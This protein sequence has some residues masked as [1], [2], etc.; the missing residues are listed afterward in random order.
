MEILLELLLMLVSELFGDV[1]IHIFT[2][3]RRIGRVLAFLGYTVLGAALGAGSLVFVP[4][5]LIGSP[6]LR[7][8][9]LGVTPVLS[10][11]LMM[12][13]GAARRRRELRVVGLEHFTAGFVCALAFGV[14]RYV[15][16]A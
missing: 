5:H 14:V 13:I 6:A 1:L 7:G 2:E 3:T 15:F 9:S 10:G 11:L 12:G 8:V 4:A 16:A